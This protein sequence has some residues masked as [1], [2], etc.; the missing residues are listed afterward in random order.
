MIKNYTSSVAANRSVVP[1]EE[2]LARYGAQSVKI[3]SYLLLT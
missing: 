3:M 2:N 1:I